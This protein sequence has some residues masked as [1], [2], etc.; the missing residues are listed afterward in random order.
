VLAGSFVFSSKLRYSLKV[1]GMN[2][3]ELMGKRRG[4][5]E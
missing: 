2:I 4:A 5:L 3:R 1:H